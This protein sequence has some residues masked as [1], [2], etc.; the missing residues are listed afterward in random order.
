MLVAQVV[1]AVAHA[2][3]IRGVTELAVRHR[4]VE[5]EARTAHQMAVVAVVDAAIVEEVVVESTRRIDAARM[6]EGHRIGDVA[7]QERDRTEIRRLG[8]HCA[9][10]VCSNR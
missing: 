8:C 3:Q 1:D 5:N 2:V 4:V 6:V 9:S 10:S 7:A